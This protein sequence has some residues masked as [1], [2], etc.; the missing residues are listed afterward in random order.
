MNIGER[1]R[2]PGRRN[3]R[4]QL[5]LGERK[6]DQ[7]IDSFGVGAGRKELHRLMVLY[8]HGKKDKEEAAKQATRAMHANS[9][10]HAGSGHTSR[11]LN[12]L[13][14]EN[15]LVKKPWQRRGDEVEMVRI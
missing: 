6:T 10:G 12:L 8:S 7:W 2:S 13:K 4:S 14:I 11:M 9:T 3:R 15:V 5:A 1:H